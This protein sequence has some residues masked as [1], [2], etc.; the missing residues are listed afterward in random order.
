MRLLCKSI[1]HTQ[2]LCLMTN[3]DIMH[4]KPYGQWSVRQIYICLYHPNFLLHD[5][6][7]SVHLVSILVCPRNQARLTGR[8]YQGRH[9]F[10]TS[11]SFMTSVVQKNRY[12]A[13]HLFHFGIYAGCL[14]CREGLRSNVQRCNQWILEKTNCIPA[15]LSS[16]T[17]ISSRTSKEIPCTCLPSTC[18]AYHSKLRQQSA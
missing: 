12:K 16:S 3:S 5:R 13:K 17:P 14:L 11:A 4:D 9:C 10:A 2:T 1:T 8:T 6:Q 7:S 15:R 18:M